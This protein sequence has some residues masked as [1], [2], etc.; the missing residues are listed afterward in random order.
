MSARDEMARR[1]VA[2]YLNASGDYEIRYR[3]PGKGGWKTK[4]FKD[5]KAAKKWVEK[6]QE[7][8]APDIE[9]RWPKG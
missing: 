7:G 5:E 3:I 4:S 2:R 9:V 8:D 6:Q 1:I